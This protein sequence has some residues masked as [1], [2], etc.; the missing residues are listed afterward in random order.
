MNDHSHRHPF[1]NRRLRL[2][3]SICSGWNECACTHARAQSRWITIW[4]AIFSVVFVFK[5]MVLIIFRF[6]NEKKTRK[7]RII[8]IDLWIL[9]ILI[10]IFS[11]C[12][13]RWKW[14][15]ILMIKWFSTRREQ[16]SILTC[17]AIEQ[18]SHCVITLL[19]SKY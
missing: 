3:Q 17:P 1:Y 4:N 14:A 11:L 18:L 13:Q 19:K 15:A 2:L 6:W 7:I 5:S 16:D 12:V 8:R 10:F 9:F